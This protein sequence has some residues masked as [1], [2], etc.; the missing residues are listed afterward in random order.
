MDNFVDSNEE[1]RAT[2][3][4]FRVLGIQQIAI[5]AADR[6]SLR[7][8]WVDLLGLTSVSTF[9][10]ESENVDEEVLRIGEGPT[11]VEVDLMQPLNPERS[12]RVDKP[13]LNHVGLWVSDIE[14]AHQYLSDQ[15][16]RFA[17]GGIRQGA[18]G[19]RVCFIHPK[20]SE[21]FPLAG[22]GVLIEL[23]QAPREVLAFHGIESDR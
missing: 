10:S 3:L 11:S 5:G 4:P 23:V 14:T 15:G 6:T 7:A 16:V 9:R 2:E 22:S 13:A 12:P 8:L 18:S 19:H 20:S 17:P 21:A 1:R